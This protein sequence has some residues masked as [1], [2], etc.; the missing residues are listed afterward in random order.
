M[1]GAVVTTLAQLA[2][3]GSQPLSAVFSDPDTTVLAGGDT[4]E[5]SAGTDVLRGFGGDDTLAAGSNGVD[6]IYGGDGSDTLYATQA[7]FDFRSFANGSVLDGGT[8]GSNIDTLATLGSAD[9]RSAQIISIEKLLLGAVAGTSSLFILDSTQFGGSGLS[10]TL[11]VEAAASVSAGL[12]IWN[13]PA[14]NLDL[15]G[16]TFTGW[17]AND[18]ITIIGGPAAE[19]ITGSGQAD[20][21]QNIESAD[22]LNGGGGDDVFS[23]FFQAAT[24]GLAIDGGAGLDSLLIAGNVASLSST[25]L[26]S[27]EALRFDPSGATVGFAASQIGG[28]GL[29]SGLAV[30]GGSGAELDFGSD[31]QPWQRRSLRLRVHDLGHGR[32]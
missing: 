3:I 24:P 15:S 11:A 10:A 6:Q 19:T 7:A 32:R 21:F 9:L 23:L 1:N 8:G 22:T 4:M 27:I 12:Q 30:T 13:T 31:R 18:F 20:Y 28:A 26:T 5:G 16:L 29:A 2:N 17:G 14:S 25:S